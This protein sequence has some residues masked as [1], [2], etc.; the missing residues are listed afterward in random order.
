MACSPTIE[1]SFSGLSCL[2]QCKA[3]LDAYTNAL[4]G[5]QRIRIQYDNYYVEYRQS[6]PGDLDQLRNLYMQMRMNC[7]DAMACLPDINPA[8]R[9]RRGPAAFG[10]INRGC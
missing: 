8:R 10:T 6:N 3:L 7:P 5:K 2:D 9:V 4:I 1:V